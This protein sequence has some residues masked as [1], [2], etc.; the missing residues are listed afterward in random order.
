MLDFE[1]AE[2]RAGPS[3]KGKPV[4]HCE[5]P[6]EQYLFNYLLKGGRQW[7]QEH[8]QRTYSTSGSVLRK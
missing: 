5:L 3:A 1:H 2:G 7:L 4:V 8:N 6:R